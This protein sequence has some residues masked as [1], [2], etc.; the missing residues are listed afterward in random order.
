MRTE[1]HVYFG[2]LDSVTRQ[3][4]REALRREHADR[5]IRRQKPQGPRSYRPLVWA[6][7]VVW[8]GLL[9]WAT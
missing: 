4:E 6:L 1:R 9:W 2:V 3:V 8:A 7:I 5:V